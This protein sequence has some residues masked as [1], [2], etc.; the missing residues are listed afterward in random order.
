MD[1]NKGQMQPRSQDSLSYP[2]LRIGERTWERGWGRGR[3]P[4]LQRYVYLTDILARTGSEGV[5]E[6]GE[7]RAVVGGSLKVR[8]QEK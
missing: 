6:A 7:E 4:A 1:S 5:Q 2:S 3:A 8:K